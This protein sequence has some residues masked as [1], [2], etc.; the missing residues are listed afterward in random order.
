MTEEPKMPSDPR[1]GHRTM[2]LDVDGEP[3]RVL[4]DPNMSD[5]TRAA[6][7]KLVRAARRMTLKQWRRAQRYGG[8][9]GY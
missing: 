2:Y 1:G 9:D 7:E 4:A 6:I 3:V 5:E 8:T